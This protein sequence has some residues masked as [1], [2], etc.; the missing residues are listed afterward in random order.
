MGRRNDSIL[1]ILLI[2]PWWVSVTVSAITYLFLA[3]VLPIIT[4]ENMAITILIKSLPHLAPYFAFILLIPAP[5]SALN[6]IRKRRMLEKQSSIQSLND[7]SWKEF[8]ELVG[9]AYRRQGFAV[10]ENH[11]LGADG[12]VDLRLEK[13]GQVHLVQCKQWKSQKVGVSV[14][15]EMFGVMTGESASSVIV[16]SSGTF[17]SEAHNFAAGK[18][19]ILIEGPQLLTLISEVQ[20]VPH[21][22]PLQRTAAIPQ[23][24]RCHSDLV[25]RK[26]KKGVNAGRQF[27]GCSAFPNCRYT[28]KEF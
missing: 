21:Q 26:A 19:I 13:N 22:T 20:T 12:G 14:V 8:E 6:S 9:E 1:D 7:L 24:P 2:L 27:I 10:K 18:P 23:C 5:F 4:T 28:R 17:T 11:K 16:I 15:R 25:W 3:F